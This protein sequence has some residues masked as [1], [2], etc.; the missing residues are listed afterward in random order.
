MN[1]GSRDS[2]SAFCLILPDYCPIHPLVLAMIWSLN[3]THVIGLEVIKVSV[4]LL[5][6]LIP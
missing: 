5:E 2:G 4:V 6:Y 3:I 1:F